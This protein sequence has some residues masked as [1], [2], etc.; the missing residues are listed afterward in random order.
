MNILHV[1]DTRKEC[2]YTVHRLTIKHLKK[3]VKFL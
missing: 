3:I 2:K 1:A